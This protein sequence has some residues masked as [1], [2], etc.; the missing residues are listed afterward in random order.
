MH[1]WLRLALITVGVVGLA[2]DAGRAG[3]QATGAAPSVQGDTV[4]AAYM[5][6]H[7]GQVLVVHAAVIRGDLAAV[8][9]AARALAT[10]DDQQFPAGA[11]DQVKAMKA[12]AARAADATD[13]LAAGRA[14]AE[15]LTSCGNCH[16]T[17]GTRPAVPARPRP[18][19][20]GVVGHMLE[21]Q[22]AADQLLE[23]LVIPS[24]TSWRA[25][26]RALMVAPLNPR[27]L[28]VDSEI[29][30]QLAPTEERVHRLATDAIQA[31][32]PLA[33]AGFYG[34][35]LAGCADCHRLHAKLW[36]PKP[37]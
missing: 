1:A 7:L 26:A 14:T 36:G 6:A 22:L 16:R 24:D 20:G 21:H 3:R 4:Q 32:D 30:R 13:A 35:V 17:V 15:M 12:A 33:R 9:P 2:A 5:K 37:R 25:G 29:R 23:G 19:V 28:P 8:G 31:T 11:P 18:E 27:E 10:L 34:Q